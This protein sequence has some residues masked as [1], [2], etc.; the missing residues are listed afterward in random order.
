MTCRFALFM[1]LVAVLAAT[2]ARAEFIINQ[3]ILEFNDT[4]GTQ[5]DIDMISRSEGSDYVVTEVY[6]VRD[7]GL[8]SE[9]KQLVDDPG[10]S[11]LVVTPNKTILAG[12]S[13]QVLRFVLLDPLSDHER[14]FRVAVKPVV[15]DLGTSAKMGLK[16]LV[17]YEVL[18]IVRPA[19]IAPQFTVERQGKMLTVKNRG[20]SNILLQ[21]VEQ[22]AANNPK[23]CAQTPP[24]RIYPQQMATVTLP[25]DAPLTTSIWDGKNTQQKALP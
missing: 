3:A 17:G 25:Y 6:E 20:N 22:C 15:G 14:I 23:D 12:G 4:S 8:P 5:Q 11:G 10:K 2:P 19:T 21:P 16:V 7:A 24:A 13:R 18:V 1:G 9:S